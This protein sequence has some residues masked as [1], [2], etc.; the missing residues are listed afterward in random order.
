MPVYIPYRNQLHCLEM[1]K[2]SY[3]N[4]L[5]RQLINAFDPSLIVY[6]VTHQIN[7]E[8]SVSQVLSLTVASPDQEEVTITIFESPRKETYSQALYIRVLYG[9]V[10]A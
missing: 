3:Q 10:Q 9:F 4:Q 7:V 6:G 1:W 8:L 5:K 2:L